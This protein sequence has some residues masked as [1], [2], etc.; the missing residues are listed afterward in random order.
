M[1]KQSVDPWGN[2]EVKL[3][4]KLIKEFGLK[5]F[6]RKNLPFENYF[7]E[8]GIILAHRLWCDL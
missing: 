2:S 8:R 4:E 6:D 1:A 5:K 7:F 3:D